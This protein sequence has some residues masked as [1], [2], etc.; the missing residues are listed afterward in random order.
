MASQIILQQ[1]R[2]FVDIIPL[3]EQA[4][5]KL[6]FWGTRYVNLPQLNS[7]LPIDAIAARVIEMIDQNPHFDEDERAHGRRIAPLIDRIYQ[8]SEQQ[9]AQCNC[10]TKFLLLLRN[11]H[12]IFYVNRNALTCSRT[13][14]AWRDFE[15]FGAGPS[16]RQIFSYYTREQYQRVFHHFPEEARQHGYV[17]NRDHDPQLPHWSTPQAIVREV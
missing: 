10:F 2:S 6:S 8:I 9:V 15:A 13:L 5:V 14:Y 11:L 3:V 16:C 4:E 17:T 7:T 1:A 12:N